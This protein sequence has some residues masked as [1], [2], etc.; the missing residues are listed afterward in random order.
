VK[1]SAL[2]RRTPLDRTALAPKHSRK[3]SKPRRRS[4]GIPAAVRAALKQRS[5]GECEIRAAGC[6]I[7]AVDPSHRITTGMGGRHGKAAATH[8]VL[9]NLL[10]TCRGCHEQ[11]V[12]RTPAVA[13]WHG[14]ALREGEDPTAVPVLYRG[15]W[16]LLDN[17]GGTTPT[18]KT[19]AD[20]GPPSP[21]R[22]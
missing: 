18:D 4:S 15:C 9:A 5:G 20:I 22:S 13:Y 6:D 10:H 21:G 1:R 11:H 7:R 19:T 17:Q 14:W 2:A 16:V 12:H 3:P 8:H